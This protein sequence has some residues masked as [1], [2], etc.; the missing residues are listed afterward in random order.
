MAATKR[1]K[2]S[3]AA[4][5]TVPATASQA[6]SQDVT[7]IGTTSPKVES[8]AKV[9]ASEAPTLIIER[10]VEPPQPAPEPVEQTDIPAAAAPILT[11]A[12]P[13]QPAQLPNKA[14]HETQA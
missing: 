6:S 5:P 8:I 12:A 9:K 13:V 2:R 14:E 4:S 10:P 1:Q 7:L 11:G 3:S